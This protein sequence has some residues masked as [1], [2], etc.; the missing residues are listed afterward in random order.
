MLLRLPVCDIF[1]SS[2][3]GSGPCWAWDPEPRLH[4]QCS[5]QL[6]DDE[7]DLPLHLCHEWSLSLACDVHGRCG[8]LSLGDSET[9]YF[10]NNINMNCRVGLFVQQDLLVNTF[11]RPVAR[12]QQNFFFLSAKNIQMWAEMGQIICIN[13]LQTLSERNYPEIVEIHNLL[14]WDWANG[15][16]YVMLSLTWS[17]SINSIRNVGDAVFKSEEQ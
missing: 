14:R 5:R 13:S 6:W 15:N 16:I 4:H 8:D 9:T 11:L 7:H 2:C 12:Q 1:Q 3:Q 10:M 17:W